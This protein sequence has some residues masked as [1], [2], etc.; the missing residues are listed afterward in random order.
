MAPRQVRSLCVSAL[1]ALWLIILGTIFCVNGYWWGVLLFVAAGLVGWL[2]YQIPRWKRA[3][4]TE[5]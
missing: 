1:V 5:N 2:A 4:D 3:L